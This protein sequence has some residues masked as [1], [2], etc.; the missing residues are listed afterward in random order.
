MV[1]IS[2]IY[3]IFGNIVYFMD[4]VCTEVTAELYS[5]LVHVIITLLHVVPR[6]LELPDRFA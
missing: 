6:S 4:T 5:L 3:V 1:L 2:V